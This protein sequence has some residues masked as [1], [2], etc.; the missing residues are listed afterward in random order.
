MEPWLRI[1]KHKGQEIFLINRQQAGFLSESYC[2]AHIDTLRITVEHYAEL[3]SLL[4]LLF[5]VSWNVFEK[6]RV[7]FRRGLFGVTRMTPCCDSRC[8]PSLR[9]RTAIE[10]NVR[11]SAWFSCTKRVNLDWFYRWPDGGGSCEAQRTCSFMEVK[12]FIPSKYDYE[13]LNWTWQTRKSKPYYHLQGKQYYQ[14][15]GWYSRARFKMDYLIPGGDGQCQVEL[16][17]ALGQCM[18]K[19]N[20]SLARMVPDIGEPKYSRQLRWWNPSCYTQALSGREHW[21]TRWI[22]EGWV[23][24]TSQ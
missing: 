19:V 17:E 24:H 11:W 7:T 8:P 9:I 5:I 13:W 20:S 15:L 2:S 4:H 3:W 14:N 6:S 10:H 23:R 21:T 16:R 12:P 18:K 22:G 1:A